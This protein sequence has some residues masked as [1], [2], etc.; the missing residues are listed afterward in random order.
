MEQKSLQHDYNYNRR[1]L[2]YV[3]PSWFWVLLWGI[4]FRLYALKV[5]SRNMSEKEIDEIDDII[6]MVRTMTSLGIP[7]TGLRTLDEMKERV[8][9]TCKLSEKK[10]S[11]TAKEVRFSW[12]GWVHAVEIKLE[13]DFVSS[14]NSRSEAV[15]VTVIL[16]LRI[17]CRNICVWYKKTA[18]SNS[19]LVTSQISYVNANEKWLTEECLFACWNG[20]R[21][22][23]FSRRNWKVSVH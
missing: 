16:T 4:K 13:L 8:K 10:S 12:S 5:S 9:E 15:H 14:R 6:D 20:W 19:G 11:W 21:S 22:L 3:G 1:H 7:S 23:K 17:S 18:L 2:V